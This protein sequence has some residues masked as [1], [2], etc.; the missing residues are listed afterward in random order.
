MMVILGR[1]VGDIYF[2]KT[3]IHNMDLQKAPDDVIYRIRPI[4]TQI[5]LKP[6]PGLQV[7]RVP[8]SGRSSNCVK[9]LVETQRFNLYPY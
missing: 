4:R 5:L 7:R 3:Y 8:R 9:S 1:T 6:L 2:E